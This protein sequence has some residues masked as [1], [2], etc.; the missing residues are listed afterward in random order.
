MAK[1][2]YVY[3]GGQMAQT[4]AERDAQMAAWGQWFGKLGPAVADGGNPFGASKTVAA[5]GS[6]KDG[7]ASD[8]GG[9][10]I[11]NADS[12][13]AATELAKGCP[14]FKNGGKVE[15]YETIDVM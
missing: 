4:E 15:V 13:A 5:G 12:L 2:V 14:I 10:S 9:Y 1:F 6:I 11:V 7:A 3:S 8:L